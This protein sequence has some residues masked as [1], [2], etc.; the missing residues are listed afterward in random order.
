[1]E[2]AKVC[3]AMSADYIK[4]IILPCECHAD[5]F[6]AGYMGPTEHDPTE[7]WFLE[8]FQTANAKLPLKMRINNAWRLLLGRDPKHSEDCV[9]FDR[10]KAIKLRDF[11]N[12]VI[13]E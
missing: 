5:A 2:Q 11:L 1:L 6:M 3:E 7:F 8:F 13:G 12:E 4:E 9:A 10:D